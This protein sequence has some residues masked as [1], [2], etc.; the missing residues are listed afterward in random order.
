MDSFS[1][2]IESR[3]D[4]KRAKK[5]FK[6]M[7]AKRWRVGAHKGKWAEHPPFPFWWVLRN[8]E[9]GW[10]TF[11]GHFATEIALEGLEEMAEGHKKASA[12]EIDWSRPQLVRHKTIDGLIVRND[13]E[14]FHPW[15]FDGIVVEKGASGYG[16]GEHRIWPKANFVFHAEIPYAERQA[17]WVEK[18]GIKVGSKVRVVRE[19]VDYE[20]GWAAAW[21]RSMVPSVGKIFSVKEAGTNG[22]RLDDLYWYPYFVLEP[23][24]GQAVEEAADEYA[25]RYPFA[26]PLAE[27]SFLAGAEW[28]RNQSK[29]PGK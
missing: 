24:K 3:A 17:D 6:A 18:N 28:Q 2:K 1:V 20:D 16:D 29:N 9:V 15:L 7:G 12:P 13:G 10:G 5:A 23:V 8:G 21:V 4:Q 11:P 22:V 25:N 27:I 19:A 26:S 14:N